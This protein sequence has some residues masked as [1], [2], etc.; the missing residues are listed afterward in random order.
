MASCGT[1]VFIWD[2][3]YFDRLLEIRSAFIEVRAI[4]EDLNA[5]RKRG[6][7]RENKCFE[8]PMYG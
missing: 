7:H 5:R 6:E 4:H 2:S 1:G 8:S 3:S